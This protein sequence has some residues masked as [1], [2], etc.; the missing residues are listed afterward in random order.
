M[1]LD[2]YHCCTSALLSAPVTWARA[3]IVLVW[4]SVINASVRKQLAPGRGRVLSDAMSG[5]GSMHRPGCGAD[6]EL[7]RWGECK[8]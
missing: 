6:E 2:Y 3:R 8:V 1:I 7:V 4:V 5:N